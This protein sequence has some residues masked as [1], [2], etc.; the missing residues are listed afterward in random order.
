MVI[1]N[2]KAEYEPTVDFWVA[3]NKTSLLN[4]LTQQ[5]P[6]KADRFF[7]MKKDQL[8]AIYINTRKKRG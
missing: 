6:T 8:T 5:F 1:K 2:G 7:D 3:N 4:Y